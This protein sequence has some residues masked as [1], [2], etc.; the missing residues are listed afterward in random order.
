MLKFLK[1]LK[2]KPNLFAKRRK[3]RYTINKHSGKK[4]KQKRKKEVKN[5]ANKNK[6]F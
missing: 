2:N 4:Q 6:E 5:H 3:N 1:I